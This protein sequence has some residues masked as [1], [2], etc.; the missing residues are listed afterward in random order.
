MLQPSELFGTVAVT[1]YAAGAHSATTGDWVE[2]STSALS[3]TANVQPMPPERMQLLEEGKRGTAGIIL[4]TDTELRTVSE[5]DQ[6]SGDRITWKGDEWEVVSID[7]FSEGM[8]L[9]EN[10]YEILA[11]RK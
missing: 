3:I 9:P 2:G 5:D 4:F 11:V 7:D 6:T 8:S 1:R 10:H